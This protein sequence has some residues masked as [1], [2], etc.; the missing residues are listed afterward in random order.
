MSYV[1]YVLIFFVLFALPLYLLF[2]YLV[3]L[4]QY[5]F[6]LLF[7]QKK[8]YIHLANNDLYLRS[9]HSYVNQVL[10]RNVQMRAHQN[11]FGLMQ[12]PQH[13]A[14]LKFLDNR[15]LEIS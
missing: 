5:C 2:T 6:R 14:K 3:T 10:Y 1:L 11:Q 15:T 13:W 8:V 4:G 7:I 12:F 9:Q